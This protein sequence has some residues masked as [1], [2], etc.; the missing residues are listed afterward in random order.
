[1]Q[2]TYRM[3]D[4]I[5]SYKPI[6]QETAKALAR[7]GENV[8]YSLAGDQPWS[9]VPLDEYADDLINGL[10]DNKKDEV[11]YYLVTI[12]HEQDIVG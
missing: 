7:I 10:L 6:D 12:I 4:K 11:Q 8:Q 9:S 2:K 3:N 1:M 5:K